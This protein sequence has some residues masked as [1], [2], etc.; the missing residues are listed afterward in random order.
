MVKNGADGAGTM[1]RTT[2]DEEGVGNACENVQACNF[3]VFPED[4]VGCIE[5]NYA[6]LLNKVFPVIVIKPFPL[7]RESVL[8][9]S[10]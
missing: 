2:N 8:P 6:Q 10:Q 5:E 1:M 7:V 4:D 9:V 3:F